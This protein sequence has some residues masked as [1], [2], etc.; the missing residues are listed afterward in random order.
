MDAFPNALIAATIQGWLR[1]WDDKGK[2]SPK[3]MNWDVLKKVD[4][5]L[6]S[7]ADVL[8]MET[9]L[10]KII[11]LVDLVLVTRGD[12]GA[13]VYYQKEEFIVPVYPVEEIDPTGA[14]DI[15]AVSFL[16][17]YRATKDIILATTFA[18]VVASF[19]VEG[20]GVHLPTKAAIA[21]RWA[22]Y[23]DLFPQFFKKN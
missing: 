3:E 13:S 14:G 11:E 22:A 20:V 6:M 7:E 21:E 17:K 19:V 2:I 18:H 15:F 16:A 9:V 10:D 4:I 1:Q 5:V 12:K 23:K 8:G